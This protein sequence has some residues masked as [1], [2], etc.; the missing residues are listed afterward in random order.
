MLKKEINFGL[1]GQ[2][3]E[4]L[5]QALVWTRGHFERIP[6]DV[7]IGGHGFD[8]TMRQAGMAAIVSSGEGHPVFLPVLTSMVMDVGR[9]TSDP[10]S[11]NYLHGQLS[12]EL[13][14]DN[15]LRKLDLLTD[16][17]RILVANAVEDHSKL[18]EYVRRSY[19]VEAV[20]DADRLDCLGALGPL[21]SASW[22]HNL[23]L[24]LPGEVDTNSTDGQ[25]KTM[26]Q[27]MVIR[28]MEWVDMLWTDTARKIAKPRVQAYREYLARLQG[29]ASVSYKAFEKLGI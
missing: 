14:V 24:I 1:T 16:Q 4:V 23:P 9:A 7:V 2:E 3:R 8:K 17:D 19:V 11:R 20:M 22:L 10:R 28:H 25:L 27:D 6:A 12:R 21:R 13:I 26:Y 5:E 29:E 15:L 18:N